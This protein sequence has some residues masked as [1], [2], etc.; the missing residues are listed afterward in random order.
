MGVYG[1]KGDRLRATVLVHCPECGHKKWLAANRTDFI[2]RYCRKIVPTRKAP[3]PI[4][5]GPTIDER[6][7]NMKELLRQHYLDGCRLKRELVW[8]EQRR[9]DLDGRAESTAG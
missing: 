5:H 4:F 9:F 8:L 2:C 3:L 1:I 6:I 7:E